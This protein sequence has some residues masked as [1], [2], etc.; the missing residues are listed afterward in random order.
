MGQLGNPNIFP[1]PEGD[2]A[3]SPDGEWFVNG[4]KHRKTKSSYYVVYRRSD[5]VSVRSTGFNIG[6]LASGD[7]R[8]DPSPCWN[9]SNNQ[10]LVP[11]IAKDGKSRQLFVLTI[12]SDSESR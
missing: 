9:R 1:N 3:L 8:Q 11:A 10:I 5:G 7:L 2:V 6:N 4:F 12:V